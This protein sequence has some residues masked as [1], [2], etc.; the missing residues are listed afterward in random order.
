MNERNVPEKERVEGEDA[1]QPTRA[2]VLVLAA[3]SI[4]DIEGTH[5][6]PQI[7]FASPRPDSSLPFLLS[8]CV[9]CHSLSGCYTRLF[10]NPLRQHFNSRPDVLL[11]AG[12]LQRNQS[13]AHII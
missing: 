3:S 8:E 11:C 1:T 4:T 9:D 2:V 5:S 7:T 6:L 10:C 13:A 12:M